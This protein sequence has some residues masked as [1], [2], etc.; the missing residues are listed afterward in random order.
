[1]PRADASDGRGILLG[2]RE[3]GAYLPR[4]LEEEGDR[5]VCRKRI[6]GRQVC[7][8]GD[9]KRRHEIG[10][11]TTDAKRKPAGDEQCEAAGGG[12]Q[13][14][15]ERGGITYVLKVVKYQQ[16]LPQAQLLCQR[17]GERL[18]RLLA[19]VEHAGDGGGH[20]VGLCNR[21]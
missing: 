19:H 7:Q 2:K 11:L 20:Q 16:Q 3:L 5:R 8:V 9:A 17:G 13:L 12:E 4:P 21:G 1:Q 10:V 14:T 15:Q 18:S 6:E